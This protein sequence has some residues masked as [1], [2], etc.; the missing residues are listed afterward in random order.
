MASENIGS[1]TDCY[2]TLDNGKKA[3]AVAGGGKALNAAIQDQTTPSVIV[4]FNKIENS[5]TLSVAGT[6]GDTAITVTD[7]T[8]FAVNK[9]IIIFS[10]ADSRYYFGYATDVTGSVVTLDS[11]LDFDFPIGSNVD[12][13]ISN[14]N[15]NGSLVSPQ[16]FGIRGAEGGNPVQLSVDI[17]RVIMVCIATSAVDL[18]KFANLTSLTNGVVMRRV[19]SD[20]RIDNVFNVKSNLEIAGIL[21]DYTPYAATNPVQGIDGFVCRLTF[22]GQE[23]IGVVKRLEP[24]DDLQVLIQDNLSTITLLEMIAEGHVVED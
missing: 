9:Y 5:T 19:R 6:K 3:L 1:L 23:K 7:P 22:A 20:G 17:T 24:G 21:F 13:S 4:K 16:I 18:D 11:P 15:A 8:G 2:V 10:V 12:S 14:M